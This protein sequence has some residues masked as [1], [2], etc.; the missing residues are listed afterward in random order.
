VAAAPRNTGDPVGINGRTQPE[1]EKVK[2]VRY[3]EM[4]IPGSI[5]YSSLS[6]TALPAGVLED[7]LTQKFH[8]SPENEHPMTETELHDMTQYVSQVRISLTRK[9]HLKKNC[10]DV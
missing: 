5:R 7:F 8:I 3:R 9:M 1:T 4:E 2:A 10:R 6:I